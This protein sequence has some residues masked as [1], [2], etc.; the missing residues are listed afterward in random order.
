MADQPPQ[1]TTTGHPTP[2]YK[3][4]TTTKKI[5][6][7]T[8]TRKTTKPTTPEK[9]QK[10]CC[11]HNPFT[12]LL[13]SH[14]RFRRFGTHSPISHHRFTNSKPIH[15]FRITEPTTTDSPITSRPTH[16]LN[17]PTAE[18][19]IK[20]LQKKKNTAIE[21]GVK[22]EKGEKKKLRMMSERKREKQRD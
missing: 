15:R 4:K 5:V 20:S 22:E 14:H 8:T 3:K 10:N 19:G 6:A 17:P 13:I 21:I 9:H 18:P 11:G 16:H 7:A 12:D 2:P 1:P